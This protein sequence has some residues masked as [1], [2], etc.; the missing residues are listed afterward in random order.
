MTT[1]SYDREVVGEDTRALACYEELTL[2]L[3]ERGY[4]PYRVSFNPPGHSMLAR[5]REAVEA[6]V[7][8]APELPAGSNDPVLHEAAD[9]R[10]LT[11]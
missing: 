2:A 5:S 6:V 7:A 8:S 4:P 9:G 11:A 10:L 3:V 1:I